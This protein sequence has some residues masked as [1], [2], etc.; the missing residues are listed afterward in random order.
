MLKT[1]D[2]QHFQLYQ[3]WSGQEYTKKV[4]DLEQKLDNEVRSKIA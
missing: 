2:F 1:F 3:L 4:Q